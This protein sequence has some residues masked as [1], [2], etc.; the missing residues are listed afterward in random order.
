MNHF[1]PHSGG[2][3]FYR[4]R[5]EWLFLRLKVMEQDPL[6]VHLTART[7]VYA[8]PR[9]STT[10]WFVVVVLVL[11]IFCTLNLTC[12]RRS[13][14]SREYGA[15]RR[16]AK[17][18][19]NTTKQTKKQRKKRKEERK[20]TP[21]PPP[22]L[23]FSLLTFL[24]AG[25]AIW[26]PG[27]GY[28]KLPFNGPTVPVPLVTFSFWTTERIIFYACPTVEKF[29]PIWKKKLWLFY[30]IWYDGGQKTT[31]FSLCCRATWR[32]WGTTLRQKCS[33]HVE[34]RL[35]NSR[36]REA[37]VFFTLRANLACKICL[38]KFR[39]RKYAKLLLLLLLLICL[40]VEGQ[41]R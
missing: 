23:F 26:V 11:L 19:K 20:E 24:S 33:F 22:P 36:P 41:L 16:G 2:H 38:S 13:D 18:K 9:S 34:A 39:V 21:L 27:T 35:H 30:C 4:K 17:K 10:W 14:I 12:S 40:H 15:K 29:L 32:K 37:L 3:L 28:S 5:I 1:Y 8:T 6:F 25:P 31:A 7:I